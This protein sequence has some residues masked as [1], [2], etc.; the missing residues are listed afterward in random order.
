MSNKSNNKKT[1]AKKTPFK[2]VPAKKTPSKETK[3]KFHY[4]RSANFNLS[5]CLANINSGFISSIIIIS[6]IYINSTVSISIII[7]IS[8]ISII[9]II[10]SIIPIHHIESKFVQGIT[11]SSWRPPS[12]RSLWV[13]WRTCTTWSSSLGTCA[14]PSMS[15]SSRC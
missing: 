9:I 12:R 15:V 14:S 5:T 1:P 6:V 4:V 7:I 11:F 10:I 2:K 13:R 3:E 8:I